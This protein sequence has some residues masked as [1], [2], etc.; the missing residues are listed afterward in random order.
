[1]GAHLQE[2][3]TDDTSVV[4]D[5]VDVDDTAAAGDHTSEEQS[6]L[7]SEISRSVLLGKKGLHF[8]LQPSRLN[9]ML[10]Q[11]PIR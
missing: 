4:V 5:N 9:D 10:L 7:H 3:S 8:I 11:D 6:K 2:R 1:M